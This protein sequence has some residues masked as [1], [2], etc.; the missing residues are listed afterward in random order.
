LTKGRMKSVF[1]RRKVKSEG[2]WRKVEVGFGW[3]KVKSIFLN[4]A[5]SNSCI[6]TSRAE[7]TYGSLEKRW[8]DLIVVDWQLCNLCWFHTLYGLDS[9]NTLPNSYLFS[10][11]GQIWLCVICLVLSNFDFASVVIGFDFASAF[12]QTGL[13]VVCLLDLVLPTIWSYRTWYCLPW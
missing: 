12:C 8:N 3:R 13:C 9:D 10:H 4:D 1:R 7:S 5:K 11:L 2:D 6:S